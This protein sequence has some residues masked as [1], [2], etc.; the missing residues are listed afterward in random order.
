MMLG[1]PELQRNLWLEITAQR[2]IAVPLVLGLSVLAISYGAAEPAS[3]IRF[4]AALGFVV[5]TAFWGARQASQSLSAEFDEDTWD[6][7]RISGMSAWDMLVGKLLG[8]ASFAWYI[9]LWL[10]LVFIGAAAGRIGF[11]DLVMALCG[12]TALAVMLQALSLLLTL[13]SWRK[14]RR[15]SASRRRGLGVLL[16]LFAAPAGL[17]LLNR[18]GDGEAGGRYLIWFDHPWPMREFVIA[19]LLAFAGGA[20]LCAHRAMRAELQF[21][22]RPWT[23]IG[24]VLSLQ[25]YA[26]GWINRGPDL[27]AVPLPGL[28]GLLV[29]Q[30]VLRLLVAFA[31]A[32][33]LAYLFVFV[34]AKPRLRLSR[35]IADWRAR[36]L[37]TVQDALPLWSVNAG[38]AVLS[39]VL[40]VA[41]AAVS[42]V[43]VGDLLGLLAG[44]LAV[45]LYAVRDFAV[46][47][48]CNLAASQRR[49]DSAA[50]AYLAV[51]YLIL[52]ALIWITGLRGLVGLVQPFSAFANPL[53]LLPAAIWA[54]AAIDLLRRR[55]HDSSGAT[56]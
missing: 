39:A 3:L 34:E 43:A 49:A 54:A 6:G 13:L 15:A 22:D 37:A 51:I 4:L 1:N 24:F 9:G 26:A 47:L 46:V 14:Q 42:G 44:L 36:R 50:A 29:N 19:S 25:V 31:I 20:L 33:G 12:L 5:A 30:S 17:R 18:F 7:Q 2:L 56:R 40:A 52:P 16:V 35:L 38:L 55:W 48:W 21:R 53:W 27:A 32:L 28:S 23:W 10:L 11:V 8:G 41:T 45:L